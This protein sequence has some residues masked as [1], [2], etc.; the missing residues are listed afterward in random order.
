[1][2]LHITYL[3]IAE[4]LLLAAFAS[5][6][7]GINRDERGR[8][9]GMRTTMLVT[10][11]A[12]IS[13]LMVNVMLDMDGK[14]PSSYIGLDLMRLPLGILSGIGFIGAGTILKQGNTATGVTTAATLWF[15]TMLGM[16]FGAGLI[17]FGIGATVL[18]LLI[19]V[20][21][22]PLEKML[23]RRHTGTITVTLD[24]EGASES[25][26]R[27]LIESCH[28]KVNGWTSEFDSPTRLSLVRAVISWHAPNKSDVG[29]P[30]GLDTLRTMPG[31][32]T[33]RWE[34]DSR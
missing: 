7:F 11:A 28:C 2:L 30:A 26:I 23:R 19:L 15:T 31:V 5:M 10:L 20:G 8:P 4:R 14:V 12:A 1:M 18:G 27:H 25:D 6:L 24:T 16:L 22:K 29:R 32:A 33:F 9:A 21:L 13:M 3:Q 34:R 17:P